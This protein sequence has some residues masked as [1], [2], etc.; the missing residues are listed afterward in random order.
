MAFII[1]ASGGQGGTYLR[2]RLAAHKRP[3]VAFYPRQGISCINIK[4]TDKPTE[5]QQAEFL[6]R[7]FG[8]HILGLDKTIEENMVQYLERINSN[9]AKNAVLAG[10]MSL[11]GP[12]FRANKIENVFCL[13]RHPLHMMISLLVVRHKR[14]AVRYGGINSEACVE[15]Y[16]SLWNAIAKDAIEGEVKIIR[17]EYATEDAKIIKDA[18][19]RQVFDGLHPGERFH[20]F[21][22]PEFEQQL[23]ELTADNYFKMYEKWE[24]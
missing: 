4:S 12:F 7:T 24:I 2:I 11:M 13:M 15:D 1:I 3:D 22:K 8:W 10:S 9:E 19:I 21:L 14:H 17:H 20:G 16:A 23:R 18:K 5:R 6:K